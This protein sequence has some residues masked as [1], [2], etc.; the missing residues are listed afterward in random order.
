[1][2]PPAEGRRSSPASAS[3]GFGVSSIS[4]SAAIERSA[5]RLDG[6]LV[7]V[8]LDLQRLELGGG[9]AAALLCVVQEGC[10]GCVQ[11]QGVS[12]QVHRAQE[13]LQGVVSKP[14]LED[15]AAQDKPTGSVADLFIFSQTLFSKRDST[16]NPY[17]F[18]KPLCG[19]DAREAGRSSIC[20]VETPRLRRTFGTRLSSVSGSRSAHL[21]AERL[22]RARGRPSAELE[23][24]RLS[25]YPLCVEW[26]RHPEKASG[27]VEV[28][29]Q[30]L[31]RAS[32]CL[33]GPARPHWVPHAGPCRWYVTAPPVLSMQ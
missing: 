27:H 5:E 13:I 33:A 4:I 22:V 26:V 30:R 25:L 21:V 32:L 10:E 20:R 28:H 1:M 29:L 8:V 12:A 31:R 11:F 3:S 18:S 9:D 7:E 2:L 15:S 23:K 24:A 14:T 19:G 16:H 6:V 17:V